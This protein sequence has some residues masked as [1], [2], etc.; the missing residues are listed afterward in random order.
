MH[1]SVEDFIRQVKVEAPAPEK[2]PGA[3]RVAWLGID[4]EQMNPAEER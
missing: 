1:V 3:H 2:H 4:G